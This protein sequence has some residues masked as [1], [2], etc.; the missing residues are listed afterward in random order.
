MTKRIKI[1]TNI[2]KE[3]ANKVHNGKYSYENSEYIDMETPL[4]ITCKIH[5]T[6]WQTPHGHLKGQGCP[7]CAKL[8]RT[9]TTEKFIEDAIKIHGDTYLYD[10]SKYVNATTPLI[11]TCKKHGD[12]IVTPTAHTTKKQ[13][14]PICARENMIAKKSKT[15]EEFVNE[16]VK[17]HGNK[18]A[19]N[20]SIYKNSYTKLTITC[21]IH[22]NFEQTPYAHLR[23]A[24]CPFC[25]E[26]HLEREM[27]LFLTENKINFIKQY[28]Q[29]FLEKQS[30][31][32]YLPQYNVAIECQ[33][34]Q[35]IRGKWFRDNRESHS[36]NIIK[37]DIDKHKKCK[38]N[39]TKLLYYV[40]RKSEL[41]EMLLNDK[42]NGIYTSDNTFNSKEKLLQKIREG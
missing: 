26:S 17:I 18:Y 38:T 11:V 29:K 23:G 21:H 5:G 1:K 13:G 34:A 7:I 19:Y 22:G 4:E 30:L 12:F 9:K 25:K 6:F 3:R 33:G 32:F 27:E 36:D 2:F 14:C 16:A 28:K 24:G 8:K 31:D 10:K 39:G 42:F 40:S 37:F 15:I 41:N 20:K 35:H